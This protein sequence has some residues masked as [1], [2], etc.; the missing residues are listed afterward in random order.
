MSQQV[1]GL[2]ASQ[3][4]EAASLDAPADPDQA[5][6]SFVD[7]HGSDDAAYRLVE[8]RA[9]VR[10]ALQMLDERDRQV[11]EMRFGE[12][13]TQG[14]IARRIGLS[15]M[16]VSRIL[17]SVLHDLNDRVETAPAAPR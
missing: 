17:R 13:L 5:V 11:I 1:D 10:A 14:E 4:Y 6:P 8:R 3:A 15:Q 7:T 2:I 12:E 16:Q 9:D